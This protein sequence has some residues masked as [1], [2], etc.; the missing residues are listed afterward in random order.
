M[1]AQKKKMQFSTSIT[2]MMIGCSAQ[3]MLK[4]AGNR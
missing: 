4:L 1:A 3:S 2:I